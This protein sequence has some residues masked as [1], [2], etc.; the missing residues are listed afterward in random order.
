MIIIDLNKMQILEIVVQQFSVTHVT[1]FF[2]FPPIYFYFYA[3]FMVP[4]MDLGFTKTSK[5][6]TK[7][8]FHGFNRKKVLHD[9]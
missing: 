9:I 7:V 4:F 6:T 1:L 3:P 8:I 2:Q 5:K